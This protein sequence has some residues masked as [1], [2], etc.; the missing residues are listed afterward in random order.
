MVFD[1]CR[2]DRI[3]LHIRFI[4]E[5]LND[6]LHKLPQEEQRELLAQFYN[7]AYQ[8]QIYKPTGSR[9]VWPNVMKWIEFDKALDV[10]C[11]LGVGLRY[12]RSKGK[13]VHGCDIA[14]ALKW[15]WEKQGIGECCTVCSAKEMPYE[16]NE[17]DLVVCNDVFEHIP[18]YDLD[19]VL[20]EIFR[21]GSDKFF[22]CACIEEES[23]PVLGEIYTHITIRDEAWWMRK[24]EENGFHIAAKVQQDPNIER[25]LFH[26]TA[27]CVKDQ[28]P[29]IRGE[30][31]LNQA[32]ENFSGYSFG[33]EKK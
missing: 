3:Y 14:E 1:E 8:M 23:M 19:A 29:Y 6:T 21:A 2:R 26:A 18:E 20:Q 17:F 13:N 33:I 27:L 12:A 28:K 5:H 10:G 22:L 4:M 16:D 30:K 7:N 9:I 25:G 15:Y 11:G 31:T 32:F 24:F